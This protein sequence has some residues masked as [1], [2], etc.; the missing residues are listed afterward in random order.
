MAGW[1]A[2]GW[3]DEGAEAHGGAECCSP[4]PRGCRRGRGALADE[5]AKVCMHCCVCNGICACR[6]TVKMVLKGRVIGQS[7]NFS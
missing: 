6:I 2:I 1:L 3:M 5:L 4:S 7:Q